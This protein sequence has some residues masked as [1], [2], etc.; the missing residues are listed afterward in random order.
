MFSAREEQFLL[1]SYSQRRIIASESGF[2]L[3]TGDEADS[4]KSEL[5]RTICSVLTLSIVVLF[6]GV[7]AFGP[8]IP[9]ARSTVGRH[10]SY[11]SHLD[12]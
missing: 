8:S 4:L 2:P 10:E 6:P 5:V 9:E 3:T 1:Y 12:R 11:S 7:S